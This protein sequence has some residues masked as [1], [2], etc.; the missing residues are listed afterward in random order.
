MEESRVTGD[1]SL[2]LVEIRLV[3][4]VLIPGVINRIRMGTWT[5]LGY[6][7]QSLRFFTMFPSQYSCR[8]FY[9]PNLILSVTLDIREERRGTMFVWFIDLFIIVLRFFFYT[10]GSH[11]LESSSSS[12]SLLVFDSRVVT[13]SLVQG[14]C[15]ISRLLCQKWGTFFLTTLIRGHI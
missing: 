12:V 1:D 3:E 4:Q 8:S 14:L 13:F 6:W 5:L 9:P 7:R 2:T 15:F 10:V 11:S